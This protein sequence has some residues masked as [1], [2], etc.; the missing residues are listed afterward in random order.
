MS[1]RVTASMAVQCI[2]LL[3]L[4]PITQSTLRTWAERGKVRRYGRDQYG[5]MQY[6][7]DDIVRTATGHDALTPA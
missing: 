6:D 2:D 5:L 1:R 3:N 4:P 7:L